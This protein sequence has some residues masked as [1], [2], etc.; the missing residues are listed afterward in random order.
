MDSLPTELSGNPHLL[1]FYKENLSIFSVIIGTAYVGK[2]REMLDA[3]AD[4][5]SEYR[6]CTLATSKGNNEVPKRYICYELIF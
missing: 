1:E 2:S 4:E 5:F 3:L 6:L